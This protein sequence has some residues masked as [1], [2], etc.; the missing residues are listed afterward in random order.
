MTKLHLFQPKNRLSYIPNNRNKR[1]DS[2]Q[3]KEKV[4]DQDEE[5]YLA[6]GN[7]KNLNECKSH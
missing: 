3:N 4:V 2:N 5:Q 6:A 1:P 7:S